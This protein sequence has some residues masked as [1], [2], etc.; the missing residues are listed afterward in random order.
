MFTNS[1]SDP[2]TEKPVDPGSECRFVPCEPGE[3]MWVCYYHL[4]FLTIILQVLLQIILCLRCLYAAS[5]VSDSD[6]VVLVD[7]DGTVSAWIS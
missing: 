3:V 7:A 2:Y 4:P 5:D 6:P 1:I